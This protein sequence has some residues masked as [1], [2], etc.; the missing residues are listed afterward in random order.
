MHSVTVL[1]LIHLINLGNLQVIPEGA[2][3]HEGRSPGTDENFSHGSKL[4]SDFGI[5]YAEQGTV[6]HSLQRI[7]Y[8]MGIKLPVLDDLPNYPIART[9][10]ELMWHCE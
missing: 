1:S 10:R 7:Y 2:Q 4:R 9:V 3:G 8:F 5:L 6:L